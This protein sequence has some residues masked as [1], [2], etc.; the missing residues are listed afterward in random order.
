M[1]SANFAIPDFL[2]PELIHIPRERSAQEREPARLRRWHQRPGLP[3]ER[4]LAGLRATRTTLYVLAKSCARRSHEREVGIALIGHACR[5][6]AACA[7]YIHVMKHH[8]P[9]GN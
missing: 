9:L 1:S 6:S 8:S 5:T 3:L 4:V 7:L 2:T